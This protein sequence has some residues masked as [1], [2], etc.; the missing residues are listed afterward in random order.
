M[1]YDEIL[2][3]GSY[4]PPQ[5]ATLTDGAQDF[6]VGPANNSGDTDNRTFTVTVPRKGNIVGFLATATLKSTLNQQDYLLIRVKRNNN[7]ISSV[8]LD[9]WVVDPLPVR[10]GVVF[11]ET[12]GLLS[13]AEVLQGDVFTLGFQKQGTGTNEIILT[14]SISLVVQYT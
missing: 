5:P 12:L 1:V 3:A 13:G 14:A 2:G 9:D 4:P 11:N 8:Y 7:L 10:S 6:T